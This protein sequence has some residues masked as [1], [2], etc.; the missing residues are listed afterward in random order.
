MKNTVCFLLL[1][2]GLAMLAVIL[3]HDQLEPVQPTGNPSVIVE[4]PQLVGGS[5]TVVIADSSMQTETVN[6]EEAGEVSAT[7]TVEADTT[8]DPV[9]LLVDRPAPAW[10]PEAD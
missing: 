3:W 6:V 4:R 7:V 10:F 9:N 2:A 8:G 5:N 1:L